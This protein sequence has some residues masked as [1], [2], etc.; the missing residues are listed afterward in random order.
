M[1]SNFV[2]ESLVKGLLLFH[3]TVDMVVE[4]DER[5][6]QIPDLLA[7]VKQLGDRP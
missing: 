1:L 5:F 2:L 7:D 3:V 4:N 6:S